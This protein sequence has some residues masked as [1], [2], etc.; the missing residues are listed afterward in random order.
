MQKSHLPTPT[1]GLIDVGM[2]VHHWGSIPPE[3]WLK[4]E[5]AYGESVKRAY[6]AARQQMT[7]AQ[8]LANCLAKMAMNS[9]WAEPLRLAL[10]VES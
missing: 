7:D 2:M 8:H 9:A 3:A 6:N 4:A 5:M 1:A 10:H